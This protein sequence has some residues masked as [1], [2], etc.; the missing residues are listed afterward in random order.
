MVI[1]LHT[2]V[3]GRS[4]DSLMLRGN[5]EYPLIAGSKEEEEGVPIILIHIL[6]DTIIHLALKK[7][8]I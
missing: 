2:C 3:G 4:R 7:E 6:T 1:W 8:T 5:V